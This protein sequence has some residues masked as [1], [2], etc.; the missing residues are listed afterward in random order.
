M[1]LRLFAIVPLKYRI[2][3]GLET[4]PLLLDVSCSTCRGQMFSFVYAR[5]LY[6]L[7]SVTNDL[8]HPFSL[9]CAAG[10]AAAFA[11]NAALVVN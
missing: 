7:R 3:F 5:L 11:V 6:S 4:V 8:W 9:S 2:Y 10:H 1:N